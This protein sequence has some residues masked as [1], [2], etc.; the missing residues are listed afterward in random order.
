MASLF[1]ENI[2]VGTLARALPVLSPDG[3]NAEGFPASAP[4]SGPSVD[5]EAG[6][7]ERRLGPAINDNHLHYNP[8][9]NV[10][11]PG[12]PKECEAGNETYAKGQTVIG[13]APG[14]VGTHPRS[15]HSR[16]EPVRADVSERHAEEPGVESARKGG[17]GKGREGRDKKQKKQGKKK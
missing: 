7:R 3:V 12:Q 11:G 15:D 17:Q 9:P 1:S 8:Y 14:N 5:R 6:V 10:A 16:T 13:H 4:A 2:G